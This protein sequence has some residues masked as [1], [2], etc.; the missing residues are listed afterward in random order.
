[1]R[2][3]LASILMGGALAVA[4]GPSQA[5]EALAKSNGCL[6][7]HAVDKKKMGPALKD[8]GAAWK[9]AG[10]D[11]DKAVAALKAKHSGVKASDAD[12]KAIAG[13]ILTL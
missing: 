2:M 11:A 6:N 5:S 12:L 4:A 7:C 9:K 1:M 13:W 8:A 3:L 10:V